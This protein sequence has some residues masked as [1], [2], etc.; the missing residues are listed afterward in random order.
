MAS[1][2][3]DHRGKAL[4]VE[5]ELLVFLHVSDALEDLG[6]DVIG[7]ATRLADAL[8]L[9]QSEPHLDVA[10]LDVNL[11]GEKSWPVARALK[12]RGIPF[13]FVSGYLEAQANCPCDLEGALFL[14]KPVDR[15]CLSHA[16]QQVVRP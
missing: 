13:V 1:S 4:L 7:S 15:L 2:A 5:D 6:F 11:A 9:V 12:Q 10:V 14:S 8:R 16:L 3:S